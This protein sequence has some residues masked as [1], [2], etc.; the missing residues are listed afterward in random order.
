[1]VRLKNRHVLL[2]VD[3]ATPSAVT[4]PL[5][6]SALRE[7]ISTLFGDYGAAC[8]VSL[9]GTFLLFWRVLYQERV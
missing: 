6:L 4:L 7:A 8:T 9:A 1:M 2:R 3:A 5:L